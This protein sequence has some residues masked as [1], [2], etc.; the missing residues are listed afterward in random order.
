[1]HIAC[2]WNWPLHHGELHHLDSVICSLSLCYY[3][4]QSR[5]K[6]RSAILATL[7]FTVEIINCIYVW[8]VS[9][10]QLLPQSDLGHGLTLVC[11]YIWHFSRFSCPWV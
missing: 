5:E 7:P 11:D 10:S 1:M 3:S 9:F 4:F 8:L 6:W 2:I